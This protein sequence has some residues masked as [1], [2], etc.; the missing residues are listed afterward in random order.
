MRFLLLSAI[1]FLAGLPVIAQWSV[2]IGG[3]AGLN[4]LQTN[5][6]NRPQQNLATATGVFLELPVGYSIPFTKKGCFALTIQTAFTFVQKGY[7]LNR[8]DT[9]Q[10]LDQQ[11]RNNYVQLPFTALLTFRRKSLTL[12]LG[13]GGYVAY[14]V[15]GHI[16]GGMP[17]IFGGT[18]YGLDGPY[19]FD[20]RK[21]NR[22]EEGWTAGGGVSV[23]IDGSL[24][25]FLAGH[26]FQSLT[27]QQK[28]YMEQQVPRYNSTWALS[29]GLQKEFAW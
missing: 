28:A 19:V 25:L 13:G 17:N 11:Y 7:A 6:T 10:G 18:P 12:E 3:G 4:E 16:Q 5:I 20:D 24:A 21:D 29:L 9:L 14:W 1:L 27:D 8:T 22:W 26:F 15:S 23:K 2:G